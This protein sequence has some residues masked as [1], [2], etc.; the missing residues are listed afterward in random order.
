MQLEPKAFFDI[1]FLE[2]ILLDT[3]YVLLHR[4]VVRELECVENDLCLA[5]IESFMKISLQISLLASDSFVA[6]LHVQRVV[7]DKIVPDAL[8][9]HALEVNRRIGALL[10]VNTFY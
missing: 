8:E 6:D 9:R 10:V 2:D 1:V 7:L 5:V 4:E 3:L